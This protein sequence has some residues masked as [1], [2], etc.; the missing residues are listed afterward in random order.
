[1]NKLLR[2]TFKIFIVLFAIFSFGCQQEPLPPVVVDPNVYILD[3]S[4]IVNTSTNS[5]EVLPIQFSTKTLVTIK[6]CNIT[7][8]NTNKHIILIGSEESGAFNH[9][10]DG[11][12]ITN[13]KIAWTG[14]DLTDDNEGI[15]VGY[16]VDA[17][18][19]YN[20]LYNCPY[21]TP[22][23]GKGFEFSTGG[24]AYNIYGPSFKVG[25]AAKGVKN[26][27]IYN[28]T[29]YNTRDVGEGVIGSIYLNSNPDDPGNPSSSGCEIYNNIFYTKHEV[30]NIYVDSA[31]LIGLKCDYNIYYCEDTEPIVKVAGF[32][33]R[34][35]TWKAT[36]GFDTHSIV[37]N[38]NFNDF[39]KLVPA[40]ALYNGKNLGN[41]WVN[42]IDPNNQW[43]G[44]NPL[45]KI[46]GSSWQVGAYIVN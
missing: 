37:V 15:L 46:Q 20:F 11:A 4:T 28:N 35:S 7:A 23:K 12:T 3:D 6:N 8:S 42:G 9:M 1:M 45:L 10:V 2:I 17:T 39:N 38:P 25:A 36:Y 33:M 18:I 44:S 41:E 32:Q 30:P 31:S 14:T 13:N 21:G 43:N 24:V 40:A 22:V 26:L 27:K 19:Q 5:V 16:S 29:F 34:L